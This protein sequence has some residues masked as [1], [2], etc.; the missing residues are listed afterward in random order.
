MINDIGE[1]NGDLRLERV[2]EGPISC[3]R[4]LFLASVE[5]LFYI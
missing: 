2:E 4:Y 1:T 5:M 3:I